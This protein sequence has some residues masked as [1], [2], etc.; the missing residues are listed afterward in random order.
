MASPQG[1]RLAAAGE[2]DK[3]ATG[4]CASHEDLSLRQILGDRRRLLDGALPPLL[5]LITYRLA[6]AVLEPRAA[7]LTAVGT[8]AIAALVTAAARIARAKPSRPALL[9]LLSVL[10]AGLFA[11]LAG[12]ARA[13]FL[14]GIVVDAVYA[15]GL[16]ASVVIGWPVVGLIHAKLTRRGRSW[17]IDEHARQRYAALTLLWSGAYALR[18]AVQI[19]FYSAD[20]ITL[21]ALSKLLL[22]W[23]LTAL[24][25]VLTLG[26]LRRASRL[27]HVFPSHARLRQ[28][29]PTSTACLSKCARG[30]G[31]A[32]ACHAA[33]EAHAGQ[34]GELRR[35]HA[36]R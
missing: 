31:H 6:D 30:C 9:G 26:S 36:A 2:P 33:R 1:L 13:Y 34:G 15:V 4:G 11:A 19:A 5:F 14:P 28:S 17:R 27:R 3:A 12:D 7:V 18:A 22:G 10:A 35:G 25:M 24:C 16:A 29:R 8:S 32:P 21:V 20:Q 23:P